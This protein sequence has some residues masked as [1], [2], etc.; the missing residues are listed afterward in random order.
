MRQS[1]TH[2]ERKNIKLGD[3]P[4]DLMGELFNAKAKDEVLA[5]TLTGKAFLAMCA[6]PIRKEVTFFHPWGKR[7]SIGVTFTESQQYICFETYDECQNFMVTESK[8]DEFTYKSDPKE[9]PTKLYI[10]DVD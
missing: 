9:T 10:I 2:V 5:Y 4:I 3:C 7:Q 8:T 1:S 6:F